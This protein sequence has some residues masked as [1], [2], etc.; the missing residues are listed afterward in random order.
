LGIKI[1]NQT[2]SA[3]PLKL[4]KNEIGDIVHF[5]EALTDTTGLTPKL[6]SLPQLSKNE[7][8]NARKFGGEY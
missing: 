8:L 7:Q 2:L 4:N 3:D 6:H 5:L 1:D